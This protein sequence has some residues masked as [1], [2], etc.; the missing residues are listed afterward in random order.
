M[1]GCGAAVLSA[2]LLW[3]GT[4]ELEAGANVDVRVG[5]APVLSATST[6]Q[7]AL[8]ERS[9]VWLSAMPLVG[10]RWVGEGSELRALAASRVL[11]R[12][13]PYG[14]R[15]PIFLETLEV[16]HRARSSERS[17]WQLDLRSTYGEEDYTSLLRQFGSN[18][19]QLPSA[20]SMF[21]VNALGDGSW[22]AS[23]RTTLSLLA[24]G[25]YR[26]SLDD[27]PSNASG[28]P[29]T[30]VLPTQTVVVVTP[31]GRYALDRRTSFEVRAGIGD[32]HVD[33]MRSSTAASA[34]ANLLTFQPQVG[35]IR[36]VAP[37]Q[38]LR[39]FAG[40]TYVVVLKGDDDSRD[41]RALTPLFRG[42][43]SSVLWRAPAATLRSLL[44]LEAA[45]YADPV[46][47]L[48]VWRTTVFANLD[49]QL[50]PRWSAGA[51]ASFTTDLNSP[52]SMGGIPLDETIVQVDVP[53][54]YRWSSQLAVEVGGRYS[55]RAPSLFADEFAWHYR[56][57]W[58][59]VT[60]TGTTHRTRSR[61][62]PTARPTSS[63]IPGTPP[64]PPTASASGPS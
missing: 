55:E 4:T 5:R 3:Q 15:R 56:E 51:R 31:A 2:L 63:P 10:G 54:R 44:G 59:F 1:V 24:S 16:A 23:R 39:L 45:W 41:W 29:A 12:P 60:L 30:P 38:Q 25:T 34:S 47:G 27:L 57:L 20:L 11:W 7:T 26:Q 13:V 46:L 28:S 33:R 14:D 9:Q 61:P 21:T 6:D 53:F 32:T 64:S 62:G 37:A 40:L 22:R 36:D 58:A 18:Q 8:R 49:A 19:P 48:A 43:L 42:D 50:G 35:V 17:R 52:V